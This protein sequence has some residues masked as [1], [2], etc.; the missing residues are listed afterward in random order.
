MFASSAT[1]VGC[2]I[3]GL[4]AV[5]PLL[6]GAVASSNPLAR[7]LA[8]SMAAFALLVLVLILAPGR[9]VWGGKLHTGWLLPSLP[10][11]AVVNVEFKPDGVT[12][13]LRDEQGSVLDW[14]GVVVPLPLD[15]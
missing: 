1:I 8:V 14:R 10:M 4:L 9:G 15:A 13:A 7:V 6:L 3:A 2:V 11:A 12:I 5:A